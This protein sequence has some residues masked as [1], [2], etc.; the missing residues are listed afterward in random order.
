[1]MNF[2]IWF[3]IG[4]LV[5]GGSALA[6]SSCYNPLEEKKINSLYFEVMKDP[7]VKRLFVNAYLKYGMDPRLVYQ[8]LIGESKGDPDKY[9]RSHK[10]YGIFHF[11]GKFYGEKRTH[12]EIIKASYPAHA[13]K[14]TKQMVQIKYY[15]NTYIPIYQHSSDSG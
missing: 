9:D 15:L 13:D 11:E 3:A 14:R 5:S 7:E 8:R 12:E 4:F 6:G 1:M 10:Q 2:G